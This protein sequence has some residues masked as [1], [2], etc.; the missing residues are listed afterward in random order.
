MG[1]EDKLEGFSHFYHSPYFSRE[2]D[3]FG[4]AVSTKENDWEEEE[5]RALGIQKDIRMGESFFFSP[6]QIK[7]VFRS[8][9]LLCSPRAETQLLAL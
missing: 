5:K 7:Y 9:G 3:R 2:K 4:R 8:S 1:K 6:F